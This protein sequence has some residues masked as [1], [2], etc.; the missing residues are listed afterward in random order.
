[1]VEVGPAGTVTTW[2]WVPQPAAQAPAADAL[3]LGARPLRRR[4]HRLP[5]RAAGGGPDEV[6]PACGC[7]P[8]SR[9]RPSGSATS[10]T[11]ATSSPW[12]VRD[13]RARAG[14]HA[15]DADPPRLPV[16]RRAWR[17]ANLQGS[18]RA[19]SSASAARSAR[20][21]TS[22]SRG[23]CPTDG[24][25]TDEIVELPNTGTVTTYCVVNV[26]FPGSP[27]RSPTSAPRSCSTGPTSP[28]WASS[29]R[30]RPPRCA[31]ACGSRRCGW[32]PRS[33]G[34]TMASV[35]YFRP[36]GEPDADYETYKEYL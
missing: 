22:P 24:V 3:R 30:S 13:E 18:S 6:S 15:G 1:M 14:H 32:S 11:S 36:T 34:P 10:R 23:S 25:P 8:S 35:K 19:S 16:H 33:S 9:P 17:S 29:R 26:P 4:R 5:P 2:S 31:W 28:S 12:E 7:G 21:S 27:S 20:R